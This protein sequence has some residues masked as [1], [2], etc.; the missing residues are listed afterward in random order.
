M[1]K[2]ADDGTTPVWDRLHGAA[3]ADEVAH[4]LVAHPAGGTV[5][6]GAVLKGANG[7]GLALRLSATGLVAW[8]WIGGG[9][10]DDGM[11][12]AVVQPDGGS[13]L[14]GWDGS[15]Q[16]GKRLGW[17]VAVNAEGKTTWAQS[18]GDAETQELVA[19]D[20]WP[21]GS[22]AL[23]GWRS[24]GASKQTWL[25]RANAAGKIVTASV[26]AG[27]LEPLVARVIG[28]DR[29][30]LAGRGTGAGGSALR[31]AAVDASAHIVWQTEH[32]DGGADAAGAIF[33]AADG[34]LAV[35]GTTQPAPSELATGLVLRADAW[36]R[37]SCAASGLCAA[38]KTS[39][40]A[41]VNP[42]T[43]D[44]CDADQGCLFAHNAVSCEDGDACTSGDV[45]ETAACK[46]GGATDCD[47]GN[48]CT[49]DGCDSKEGCTHEL[50]NAVPCPDASVCTTDEACE[51]GTCK[52]TVVSCDDSDPCSKDSCDAKLGCQHDALPDETVCE[53]G[54]VCAEGKCVARWAADLEVGGYSGC[55][56]HPQ[57]TVSCWGQGAHSYAV[58]FGS[59]YG[60]PYKPVLVPNLTGAVDLG[61]GDNHA[62]ALKDDGLAYCW[63][64]ET[65]GVGGVLGLGSCSGSN[66]SPQPA[67]GLTEAQA[68]ASGSL[69][70]LVIRKDGNV[71]GFGCNA[72]AL[73]GTGGCAKCAPTPAKLNLVGPIA[74]VR[75]GVGPISI[76]VDASGSLW[77]AG[78]TCPNNCGCY[79]N[80]QGYTGN[81][82]AWGSWGW[83]KIGGPQGV[84]DGA[85]GGSHACV[86][87]KEGAVWCWGYNADGQVGDGSKATRLTPVK[88]FPLP[89]PAQAVAASRY[90]T[91][92]A[93]ASGQVRCW[94]SNT[95]G[96]IG[97]GSNYASVV[98]VEVVG[99]TKVTKISAGWYHFCALRIDGSVWC[100]GMGGVGAGGA[101]GYDT[102]AN[103]N[104]PV[105]VY[106]SVP[107]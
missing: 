96:E 3:D 97:D 16:I 10:G 7:D 37:T 9:A 57:G 60:V 88:T 81:G 12:A 36:G 54:K 20:T 2:V 100:W 46:P 104:K 80:Q 38:K 17:L 94:G 58:S 49:T 52:L 30:L 107:N 77:A 102:N 59:K 85:V 11:R 83:A 76:A 31:L 86:V 61:V 1:L 93:L 69:H 103:Q 51:N 71:W 43:D 72:R 33:L 99:L 82:S 41:D 14:A 92:A 29:L 74:L 42:C 106:G 101:L 26:V 22:L 55:V 78:G 87:D 95:Y 15:T 98:P 68:L 19:I 32:D 66:P 35:V 23:A 5:V 67:L 8:Q 89:G 21:D 28:P 91:C 105:P 25:L 47:D 75:A 63:G 53:A 56:R 4:A 50:L 70:N 90:A 79:N 13:I 73:L 45:C 62:C 48:D 65:Y 44:L 84:T 64:K 6:V 39:D 40:C 34:G 24:F 27:G 18:L